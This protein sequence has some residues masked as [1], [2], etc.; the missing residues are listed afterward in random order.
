MPRYFSQVGDAD[1]RSEGVGLE[2][3]THA[4]CEAI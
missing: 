3:I 4:K 2:S 1:S